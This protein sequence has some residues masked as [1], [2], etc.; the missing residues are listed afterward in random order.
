MSKFQYKTETQFHLV[1]DEFDKAKIAFE[2]FS[3]KTEHMLNDEIKRSTEE[4]E[5]LERNIQQ[6]FYEPPEISDWGI[7]FQNGNCLNSFMF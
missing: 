4:D 5:R 1:E 7:A 6:K 2:G 3:A